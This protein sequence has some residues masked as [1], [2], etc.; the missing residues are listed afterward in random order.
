MNA[1]LYQSDAFGRKFEL[2]GHESALF[3]LQ[4]NYAVCYSS[5]ILYSAFVILSISRVSLW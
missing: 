5:S 3:G 1:F 4:L 2:F